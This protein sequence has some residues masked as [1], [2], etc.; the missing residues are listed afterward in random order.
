MKWLRATALALGCVGVALGEKPT[1]Y[2]YVRESGGPEQH[3]LALAGDGGMAVGWN[4]FEEVDCPTVHYGKHKDQLTQYAV[5]TSSTYPTSTT[6]NNHVKLSQLEPNTT[7]YYKVKDD[8]DVYNFT[9]AP[10]T[11][12]KE[13]FTFAFVADLGTMGPL[14]LSADGDEEWNLQP[15][16]L[17]TMDSL[18]ARIDEYKFIWHDGD[19]AYADYW[20]KEKVQGYL[21]DGSIADGPR[22]YEEI[23]N[24]YYNDMQPLTALRP[25]MVGPGNH[26][27]NCNNGG[28]EN[29]TS[30]LCVE[31]QT[32][33]TGYNAHY[34]MPS[35]ESGGIE[36]MWYSFDYG[37]VHFVQ[38]NTETDF[39]NYPEKEGMN[40]TNFGKHNEQLDWIKK[41]LQN[42]DRSKTPWV[43]AAGHRP[44]YVAIEEKEDA[45]E[46]CQEAFEQ[47]FYENGVDIMLY[48]HVHNYQTFYPLLDGKVDK[49][50]FNNPKYPVHILNGAA[51]HYDGLDEVDY[52][53]KPDGFR[54]GLS[55]YGWSKFIVHNETHLTQE[56]VASGNNSILDSFTIYK[57]RENSNPSDDMIISIEL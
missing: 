24:S 14:G 33:F 22:L 11:G 50:G 45:Q 21:E 5:G 36:N 23:L 32:N 47:L 42:V 12:S 17:N 30:S 52:D 9:T 10:E 6:W 29:Y 13:P 51:G 20:L 43:I 56:F 46:A 41:D 1:Q 19:I 15:G 27:S 16:E 57:E 53:N 3:R 48:G 40:A 25:Y 54:K 49:N 35:Q 38:F 31:G 44:W 4:T 8:D 26:E 2:I 55:V 18:K 39:P 37:Q 34:K 7:Y 28:Y